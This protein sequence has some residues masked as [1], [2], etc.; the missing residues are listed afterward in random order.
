MIH[1]LLGELAVLF[2][3]MASLCFATRRAVPNLPFIS[4]VFEV[5]ELPLPL[6]RV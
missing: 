6:Q 3:V 5:Y 4:D 2:V 1:L